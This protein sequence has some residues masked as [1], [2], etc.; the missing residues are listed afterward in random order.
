[1]AAGHEPAVCPHRPES[2]PDPGLQPKKKRT[3]LITSGTTRAARGLT[4]TTAPPRQRSA[5]TDRHTMA[6]GWAPAPGPAPPLRPRG[7][8]SSRRALRRVG[9]AVQH[10]GGRGAGEGGRA[11]SWGGAGGGR[12]A[13]LQ[14]LGEAELGLVAVR[15]VPEKHPSAFTPQM[16]RTGGERVGAA[17]CSAEPPV[18]GRPRARMSLWCCAGPALAVVETGWTA[19]QCGFGWWLRLLLTDV[20]FPALFDDTQGVTDV[21]C[22]ACDQ[23]GWKVPTKIQVEAIPVALQ[24]KQFVS[25]RS[26]G[27]SSPGAL[28]ELILLMK[29]KGSGSVSWQLA[30]CQQ[31]VCSREQ[32]GQRHP[33]W[34]QQ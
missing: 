13:E 32:E 20:S 30:E 8:Y 18:M 15:A 10:G 34:Y 6:A 26:V 24:G 23:L 12:G 16:K 21:L 22:E 9:G 11:G 5:V 2:H 3:Q 4:A 7:D 1:M 19:L 31:A 14:G 17:P 25:I 27:M 29:W 33:G 28:R